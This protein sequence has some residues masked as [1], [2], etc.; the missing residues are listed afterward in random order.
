MLIDPAPFED[1]FPAWTRVTFGPG[2]AEI[3]GDAPMRIAGDGGTWPALL[4]AARGEDAAAFRQRLCPRKR[5]GTGAAPH[6]RLQ[7]GRCQGRQDRRRRVARAARPPGG[8]RPCADAFDG[9]HGRLVRRRVFVADAD[10]LVEDETM[11]GG[12][13]Q[14]ALAAWPDLRRM[15][16]VEAIRSGENPSPGAERRVTAQ[17]RHC[18][19]SA[20]IPQNRLPAAVRTH[21]AIENGLHRVLDTGTGREP[22]P[23]ARR[24][25]RRKPRPPAPHRPQPRARADSSRASLSRR[26]TFFPRFGACRSG[27]MTRGWQGNGDGCHA[28]C[29]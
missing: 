7:Y 17:V 11:H 15:V 10:V 27:D 13:A 23:R 25:R 18:V 9:R 2:D 8:L 19:A 24:D 28:G 5:P 6:H 29:P 3:A 21:R 20:D 14:A 12:R 1:A 22:Q 4:R 16:V 26:L